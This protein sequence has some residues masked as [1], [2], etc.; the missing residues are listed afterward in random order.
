MTEHQK[1]FLVP[2][3]GCS[4][5]REFED[6]QNSPT[7][8]L[9]FLR[10]E[11]SFTWTPREPAALFLL[12]AG[13]A[14]WQHA[15]QPKSSKQASVWTPMNFGQWLV[16]P[17]QKPLVICSQSHL[18]K[19]AVIGFSAD[20][21]SGCASDYKI[22]QPEIEDVFQTVRS[23]HATV[24]TI[25]L[26]H[27]IIFE[28]ALAHQP[29]SLASQFVRRELMKEAF[30]R[31]R[32]AQLQDPKSVVPR[33]HE[34][35]PAMQRVL[36]FVETELHT[37]INLER[38][39]KAAALSESA[40]S[41]MFQR[42]LGTSPVKY[43][44]ERRLHDARLLLFTGRYRVSEVADIVGF[45]DISSFSQAFSRMFGEPPNASRPSE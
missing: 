6:N 19:F 15:D 32:A 23:M 7:F 1:T 21:S 22:D 30:Y 29:Q 36:L 10:H 11:E 14:R 45:A 39:A 43:V 18:L 37:P 33:H 41:R 13:N 27:R 40:V 35:S 31:H 42:E 24:W 20:D 8:F 16:V 17:A 44:W 2:G 9:R 38:L 5:L 25:E 3:F 12:E 4:Y 34:L 28:R 26:C